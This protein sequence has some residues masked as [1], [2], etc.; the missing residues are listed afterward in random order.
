MTSHSSH[1]PRSPASSA[2]AEAQQEMMADIAH[3]LQTPL[4]IIKG[5]LHFLKGN[6]PNNERL[7]KCE[8]MVEEMSLLIY[9]LL[10]LSRIGG[11]DIT[12]TMRPLNLTTLVREV[13]EYASVLADEKEVILE[14]HVSPD[15][16]ISG[17]RERIEELII[18]LLSNSMKYMK[19][20]GEKRITVTLARTTHEAVLTVTDTGIGISPEHM[21]YVFNRFYRVKTRNGISVSGSGLGLAIAQKIAEK[22]GAHISIESTVGLGTT[23]RV[24]FPLVTVSK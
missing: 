3:G 15:V 17:V 22:H 24:V 23:V 16:F 1:I 8:Q 19:A 10:H 9:D 20:V 2:N 11:T 12:D 13:I 14:T 18:N 21:P 7:E 6:L 5:E 4:T